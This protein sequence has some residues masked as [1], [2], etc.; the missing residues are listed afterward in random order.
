[1]QF[2]NSLPKQEVIFSKNNLLQAVFDLWKKKHTYRRPL[3]ST[4][5]GESC[6]S[7]ITFSKEFSRAPSRSR[8]SHP[9][10][11]KA[12]RI[13]SSDLQNWLIQGVYKTSPF[14][15]RNG[16]STFEWKWSS[17]EALCW[18]FN[19]VEVVG[20]NKSLCARIDT[21]INLP[22][23]EPNSLLEVASSSFFVNL[24][25][26]VATVINGSG[27]KTQRKAAGDGGRRRLHISNIGKSP[28][29]FPFVLATIKHPSNK[30]LRAQ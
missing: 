22:Y 15:R 27:R 5:S 8:P 17:C 29:S 6:L 16:M 20:R 25:T 3:S 9:R 26:V 10:A 11:V 21:K 7:P 19:D 14:T 24:L 23:F 12:R 13:G 1:M 18:L 2:K 30:W 28:F 4:L